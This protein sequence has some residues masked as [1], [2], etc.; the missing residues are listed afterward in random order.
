PKERPLWDNAIKDPAFVKFYLSEIENIMNKTTYL[1]EKV[2]E[3]LN[4]IT[5]PLLLPFTATTPTEASIYGS[6]YTMKIDYSSFLEEK[7]R[8]INFLEDRKEFVEDQLNLL[9]N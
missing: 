7:S 3:W 8:V 1:L 2:E 9:S 6:P 5:E 4:L